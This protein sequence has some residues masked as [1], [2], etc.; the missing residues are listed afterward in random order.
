VLGTEATVQREY[1]RVLI[2]DFA[3]GCDVTLVGSANLAALAEASLHGLAVD[4]DAIGREIAPC[5]VATGGRRT[6]TVVLACTHY[7]LLVARLQRL[8]PWSVD[9]IDPAPAIARRVVGLLGPP[10]A[11]PAHINARA[12]FTSGKHPSLTLVAALA[13]FGIK[14]AV[15]RE[16]A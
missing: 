1:T 6:D 3:Q 12:F 14:E 10:L 2:R 16:N 7:P 13:E 5:F 11:V 9:W 8:A 4:D 15:S